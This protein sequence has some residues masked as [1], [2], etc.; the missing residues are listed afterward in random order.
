MLRA[1]ARQSGPN[2]GRASNKAIDIVYLAKI[3]AVNGHG[4]N[5]TQA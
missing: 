5:S 2:W 4:F 3:K 1:V